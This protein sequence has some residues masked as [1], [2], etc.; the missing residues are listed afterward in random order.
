MSLTLDGDF[1]WIGDE[2]AALSLGG[3]AL[4]VPELATDDDYSGFARVSL[5]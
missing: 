5:L 3:K 1:S 2:E 4:Y